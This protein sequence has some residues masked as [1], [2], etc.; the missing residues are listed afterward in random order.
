M[1]PLRNTRHKGV[2]TRR[3]AVIWQ[4]WRYDTQQ[5]RET[6][7]KHNCR[8]FKYHNVCGEDSWGNTVYEAHVYNAI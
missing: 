2:V 5:C 8:K 6:L 1:K 4:K 3:Y 7:E